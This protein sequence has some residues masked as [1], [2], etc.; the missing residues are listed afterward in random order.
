MAQKCLKVEPKYHEMDDTIRCSPLSPEQAAWSS[1][2]AYVWNTP[3]VLEMR[4]HARRFQVS[5]SSQSETA[6]NL[7]CMFMPGKGK[8]SDKMLFTVSLLNTFLSLT[9]KCPVFCLP[10]D[11]YTSASPCLYFLHGGCPAQYFF[12]QGRLCCD[13]SENS[14]VTGFRKRLTSSELLPYKPWG[15]FLT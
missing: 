2:G 10:S 14:S 6:K 7:M 12:S 5:S 3:L 9:G 1:P 15:K 13:I 8:E 4:R 11:L